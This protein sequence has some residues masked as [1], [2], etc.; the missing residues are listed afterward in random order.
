MLEN[1]QLVLELEAQNNKLS[2]RVH[3]S[4]AL[5]I[6]LV[7]HMLFLITVSLNTLD[8]R[9]ANSYI[10]RRKQTAVAPDKQVT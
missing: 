4:M 7:Y 8:A 2:D 1:K 10:G 3:V 9:T 6:C 5:I